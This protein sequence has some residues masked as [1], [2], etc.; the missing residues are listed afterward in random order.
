MTNEPHNLE[1]HMIAEPHDQEETKGDQQPKKKILAFV[2]KRTPF[3]QMI[4]YYVQ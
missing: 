3:R 4:D 2:I 1:E